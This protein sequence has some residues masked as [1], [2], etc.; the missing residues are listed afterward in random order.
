[1]AF[2]KGTSVP[3]GRTRGEIE[4]VAARSRGHSSEWLARRLR[5]VD[6][7]PKKPGRKVPWRIPTAVI[8]RALAGEGRRAA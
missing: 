6:G 5:G 3:V 2:A 4:T 7:V 8:D 1:M